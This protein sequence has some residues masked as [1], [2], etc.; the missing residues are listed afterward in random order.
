MTGEQIGGW[1]LQKGRETTC[2]NGKQSLGCCLHQYPTIATTQTH[3]SVYLLAKG[4][5][6]S[7]GPDLGISCGDNK[8]KK[9]QEHS[10]KLA[11]FLQGYIYSWDSFSCCY[12]WITPYTRLARRK[13]KLSITLGPGFSYH[14]RLIKWTLQWMSA[15]SGSHQAMR[16]VQGQNDSIFR[17]L[18]DW[19]NLDTCT[20]SEFGKVLFGKASPRYY[21]DWVTA[22]SDTLL[23]DKVQHTQVI[24]AQETEKSHRQ[25]SRWLPMKCC[26]NNLNS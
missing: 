20:F 23:Q 6:R 17:I 25:L 16:R 18:T 14:P 26:K 24:L 13:V 5:E 15:S 12:G 10:E 22:A 11:T 2:R 1:L 9:L 19:C 3:K 21:P 7:K 4:R 8:S